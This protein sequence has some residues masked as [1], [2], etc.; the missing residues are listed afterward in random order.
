M[1]LIL[2]Q[3]PIDMHGNAVA[4][5]KGAAYQGSIHIHEV[6]GKAELREETQSSEWWREQHTGGGEGS[7]CKG[8]AVAVK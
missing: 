8:V 2:L 3:S 7:E 4:S 6:N 1:S 5:N